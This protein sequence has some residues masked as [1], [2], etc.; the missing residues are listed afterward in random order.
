MGR[1]VGGVRG[2]VNFEA[3]VRRLG[4]TFEHRSDEGALEHERSCRENTMGGPC[5]VREEAR[6]REE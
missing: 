3:R 2:M 1:V 4:T 5:D 6:Y